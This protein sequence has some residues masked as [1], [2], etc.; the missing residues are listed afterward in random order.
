MRW[1][2]VRAAILVIATAAP[3]SGAGG[4]VCLGGMPWLAADCPD[5]CCVSAVAC[6]EHDPAPRAPES[7]L[8]DCCVAAPDLWYHSNGPE[9]ALL[10]PAP[11]HNLVAAA[12]ALPHGSAGAPPAALLRRPPPIPLAGVV[13]LQV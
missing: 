6:C 2:T 9:S 10:P 4:T 5:S 8:P 13:L 1:P 7:R 11:V 12:L 3:W